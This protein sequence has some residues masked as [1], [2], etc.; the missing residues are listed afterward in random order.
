MRRADTDS[1]GRPVVV[2]TGTGVVTS[3][4]AESRTTGAN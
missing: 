1:R 4:G 3:L 2:V